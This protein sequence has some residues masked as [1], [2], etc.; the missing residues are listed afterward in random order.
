[1][2]SLKKIIAKFPSKCHKTGDTISKGSGC[3][4]DTL[5]KK[6]YTIEAMDSEYYEQ[7]L[8]EGDRK[9]GN[10]NSYEYNSSKTSRRQIMQNRNGI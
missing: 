3:Y 6:V 2:M 8:K 4:Y 10:R 7:Q 1:M 5:K 9:F